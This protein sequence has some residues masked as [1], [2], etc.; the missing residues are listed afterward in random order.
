MNAEPVRPARRSGRAGTEWR[1][2]RSNSGKGCENVSEDRLAG[3][4]RAA[5]S[6]DSPRREV[7]SAVG[8][9]ASRAIHSQEK[10]S[11]VE[12]MPA[13]RPIGKVRAIMRSDGMVINLD[14]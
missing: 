3:R 5:L 8:S 10:A 13:D 9:E 6:K 4:E 1:L 14:E 12:Q 2:R 7:G 11:K